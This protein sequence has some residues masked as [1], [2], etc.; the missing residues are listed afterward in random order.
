MLSSLRMHTEKRKLIPHASSFHQI[1]FIVSCINWFSYKILMYMISNFCTVAYPIT[2]IFIQW[3]K[4]FLFF[5][6][7][8]N[9]IRIT[10][11]PPKYS[12]FDLKDISVAYITWLCKIVYSN[13]F[14]WKT[15]KQLRG[16][17]Q[18]TRWEARI[19]FWLSRNTA[20]ILDRI[21]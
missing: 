19:N 10:R 2:Y 17:L 5:L 13:A 14:L 4:Y 20:A 16:L 8:I 7:L 11:K 6:Y 1:H 18:E 3:I 9:V 21:H 12:Y 15:I